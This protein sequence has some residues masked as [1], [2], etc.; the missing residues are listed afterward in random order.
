ME[1]SG[2][3]KSLVDYL[4]YKNG[5]AGV[6]NFSKS[7][8]YIFA[9][10]LV[11]ILAIIWLLYNHPA[12]N[13]S[14]FMPGT[15]MWATGNAL[16]Y[17]CIDL[18]GQSHCGPGGE[19]DASSETFKA[20]KDYHGH[21]RFVNVRGS[22]VEQAGSQEVIDYYNTQIASGDNYT[23]ND[24]SDVVAAT[25]AHPVV[26]AAA[27]AAGVSPVAVARASVAAVAATQPAATPVKVAAAV[28]IAPAVAPAVASSSSTSATS[29][30]SPKKSY[31]N[32]LDSTLLNA[33]HGGG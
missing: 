14:H 1:S 30:T 24:S 32:D 25:A 9:I 2:N 6:E 16:Q 28:A 19:N 10:M 8:S 29:A 17:Q 22:G 4:N 23:Y 7:F 31:F 27:A 26:V 33:V 20:K 12:V 5:L 21:S 18:A 3:D 13:K 11:M 15:D